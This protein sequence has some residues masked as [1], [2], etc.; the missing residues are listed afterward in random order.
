MPSIVGKAKHNYKWGAMVY[1]RV[2]G[3]QQ[4]GWVDRPKVDEGCS[5]QRWLECSLCSWRFPEIWHVF[6]KWIET[7]DYKGIWARNL[8]TRCSLQ[9]IQECVFRMM[10]TVSERWKN[11]ETLGETLLGMLWMVLQ[12]PM[13]R[14]IEEGFP[15]TNSPLRIS[16]FVRVS[17][18]FPEVLIPKKDGPKVRSNLRSSS[19]SCLVSSPITLR[20]FCRCCISWSLIVWPLS[21]NDKMHIPFIWGL[22]GNGLAAPVG[23]KRKEQQSQGWCFFLLL[24][25]AV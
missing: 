13:S 11:W 21:A 22:E 1:P 2:A 24:G 5:F 18:F 19:P 6:S 14:L 12:E 15:R 9:T 25:G 23:W 4:L 10:Q 8:R 20:P 7:I 17:C 16:M 3:C